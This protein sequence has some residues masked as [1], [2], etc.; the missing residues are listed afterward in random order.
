MRTSRLSLAVLLALAAPAPLVRLSAD[1]AAL[2]KVQPA[3]VYEP[4]AM[5]SPFMAP[6]A[7]A[8]VATPTPV[9]PGPHWWDQMNVTSLMEAGGVYFAAV[10]DKASG[11][12]YVLEFGK[13]DED[14]HLVLANVQWSERADQSTITV[15]KGAEVA[16][17]LRF[18]ASAV[19]SAPVSAMPQ[20]FSPTNPPHYQVP[21]S[22]NPPL[23]PGFTGTPPPPPPATSVVRR[24]G[25]IGSRPA[26]PGAA[27]P[28]VQLPPQGVPGGGRAVRP[29]GGGSQ[30][31]D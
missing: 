30:G 10:V 25:P 17:P 8:P 20:P 23:P 11:K 24:N 12:R 27:N 1:E 26:N 9:Q 3:A 28:P 21:M 18:D 13:P 16:P 19:P 22:N 4:M 14:S 2:P 29:L 7:A 31:E 5:R 15:R 6:T